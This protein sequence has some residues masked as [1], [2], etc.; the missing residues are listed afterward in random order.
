MQATAFGARSCRIEVVPRVEIRHRPGCSLRQSRRETWVRALDFKRLKPPHRLAASTHRAAA[1]PARDEDGEVG[2][3]SSAGR[4][5]RGGRPRSARRR[6]PSPGRRPRRRG[7]TCTTLVRADAVAPN[8][9]DPHTARGDLGSIVER[10][11][12]KTNIH[13]RGWAR[14]CTSLLYAPVK[15]D[16]QAT[17]GGRSG[18]PRFVV[19]VTRLVTRCFSLVLR[20]WRD[21]RTCSA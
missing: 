13:Q 5:L 20:G 14:C 18:P 7:K 21:F 10:R 17:A 8:T 12:I 1:R 6:R 3:N 16:S 11:S 9:V 4:H 2:R 19:V 15:R